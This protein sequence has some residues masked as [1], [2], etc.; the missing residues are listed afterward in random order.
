MVLV[1]VVSGAIIILAT[2]LVFLH[3]KRWR[4]K[5][6]PDP[7]S[8]TTKEN[9]GRNEF[10]SDAEYSSEEE[11]LQNGTQSTEKTHSNGSNPLKV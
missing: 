2:L 9:E 6:F 4:H 7:S 8:V 11:D 1:G 3:W 5:S 10:D